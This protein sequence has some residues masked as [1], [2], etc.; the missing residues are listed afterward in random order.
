MLSA[1]DGEILA[2][3]VEGLSNKEIAVRLNVPETT[4]KSGIQIL[5]KKAGVRTRA[6]LVRVAIENR[7]PLPDIR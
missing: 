2:A 4:V 7:R 5:F 6:S 1:R 3:L